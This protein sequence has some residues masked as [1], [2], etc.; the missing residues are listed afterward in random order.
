MHRFYELKHLGAIIEKNVR[1]FQNIAIWV[2]GWELKIR[3]KF[4]TN[5]FPKK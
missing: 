3:I 1:S 5:D 4:V 2:F